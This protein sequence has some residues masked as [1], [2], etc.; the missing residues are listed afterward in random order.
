M[1][2]DRWVRL[3][4]I[5]DVP[6]CVAIYKPYVRD[7]TITF[8]TEVPTVAEMATRIDK[9]QAA[10]EWLVLE[11]DNTGVIGYAYA[12]EFKSR[13]AYRW[14]VETSVY[15]AGPQRGGG[16]GRL[17][18]TELLR[19]LAARG[20]RRAFAGITLPNDASIAFH[21]AF[22]FTDTGV[23]R[24]VGWKLNA[25]RDVAWLQ[26]DLL[27]PELAADPPDEPRTAPR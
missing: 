12:G 19:R 15:L 20:Y 21:H 2:K 16:G 25:W 5:D 14:S 18:Y 7:T 1:T 3:A 23:F 9:A 11:T 22:G 27:P 6:A 10:Y 17:L 13:A 4:T 26:A 8:E 24:Q